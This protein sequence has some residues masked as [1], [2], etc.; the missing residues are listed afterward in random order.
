MQELINVDDDEE[1]LSN[2]DDE[3]N[4]SDPQEREFEL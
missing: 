4:V 3:E 1:E 2:T